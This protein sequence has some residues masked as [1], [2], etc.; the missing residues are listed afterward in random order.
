MLAPGRRLVTAQ[1]CSP[2]RRRVAGT[3]GAEGARD[4]REPD[5]ERELEGTSDDPSGAGAVNSLVMTR[6]PATRAVVFD[7]G[8]TLLELGYARLTAYLVSRGHDITESAVTDAERRA[9][10]RLD[11]DTSGSS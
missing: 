9:R 4:M 2:A 10:I 5:G 6:R 8:H 7:A 3:Y 1:R 11:V